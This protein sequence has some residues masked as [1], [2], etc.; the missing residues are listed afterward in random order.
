MMNEQIVNVAKMYIAEHPQHKDAIVDL[1][2]MACGEVE[3][4]ESADHELELMVES[5]QELLTSEAA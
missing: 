4:G 3:A 1:A 5:V 2:R